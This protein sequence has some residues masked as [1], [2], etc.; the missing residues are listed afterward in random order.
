[1]KIPLF[2]HL[3]YFTAFTKVVASK[4]NMFGGA[5]NGKDAANSQSVTVNFF[6]SKGSPLPITAPLVPL[7]INVPRSTNVISQS[8]PNNVTNHTTLPNATLIFH[9]FSR[10]KLNQSL[11]IIIT[12]EENVKFFVYVKLGERPNAVT[13]SWDYFQTVPQHRLGMQ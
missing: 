11:S 3:N 9:V 2:S 4:F 1:M 12:P 5:T 8:K 13:G 6:D 7:E 10:L